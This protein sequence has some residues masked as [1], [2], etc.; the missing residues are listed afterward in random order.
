MSAVVS[1][2][3]LL[4]EDDPSLRRL[5]RSVLKQ[6]GYNV[7]DVEDGVAAL[8]ALETTLPAAVVLDLGLPGLD[9]RDFHRELLAHEHTREIPVI[10]VSGGDTSDLQESEFASIF[11]KPL[12]PDS[13]LGAI[14][15]CLRR[16]RY[17]S[18]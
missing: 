4:V 16:R 1:L 8:R 2:P 13:L 7:V 14:E 5:Y 10:V 12:N 18:T 6:A 9:G 15:D 11:K 3:V 17:A